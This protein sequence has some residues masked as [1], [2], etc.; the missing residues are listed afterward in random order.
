MDDAITAEHNS[1]GHR[2]SILDLAPLELACMT[3][4]WPRS[5]ASVREIQ[6]ALAASRPRAYTTILTI[7]DRL[8]RKGMVTRVKRGRAWVYHSNFSAN[9]ARERAV[10]QVIAHF[11]GG[12]ADA[13][14]AHLA[15][16]PVM[17]EPPPLP[18]APVADA[19][20]PRRRAAAAGA[21]GQRMESPHEDSS[22]EDS[23]L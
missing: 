12:S 8:A 1:N 10:A 6:Q 17:A 18:P 19:P 15:G 23:L 7:M 11:F 21:A 2:R 16:A 9:V 20:V 22:M 4:L 3:V 14:R 13:L 5:A